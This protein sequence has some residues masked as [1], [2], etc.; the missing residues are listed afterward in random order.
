MKAL[1]K[2]PF[3]GSVVELVKRQ[4]PSCGGKLDETVILCPK[5]RQEN[6]REFGYCQF[7]GT[8]LRIVNGN[9]KFKG[10][11]DPEEG[12]RPSNYKEKAAEN[13]QQQQKNEDKVRRQ[14]RAFVGLS[15]AMVVFISSLGTGVS[16]RNSRTE[17]AADPEE[18]AAAEEETAPAETGQSG[19]F[20]DAEIYEVEGTATTADQ[21]YSLLEM[22]SSDVDEDFIEEWYFDYVLEGSCDWYILLFT[23]EEET[24]VYAV[25][26]LVYTDCVV[27]ENTDGAYTLHWSTDDTMYVPDYDGDA[28][29]KVEEESVVEDTEYNY[30]V[31]SCSMSY[32]LRDA[33]DALNEAPCSLSSLKD[34][35]EEAGYT[36]EESAYAADNCGASW[37]EQAKVVSQ[38]LLEE[39]TYS[40][41][42][43]VAELEE[44]GFTS[45]EAVYAAVNCGADWEEEALQAAENL[46]YYTDLSYDELVDEL[47]NE[48][49]FT[50]E[51][52]AYAADNCG[53]DWEE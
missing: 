44:Q 51:E 31:V 43:L 29:V 45:T 50:E 10:E 37:N 18:T 33:L 46:V 4:C 14:M 19:L 16:R 48:R 9:Y 30:V 22:E 27:R 11:P 41:D 35:L 42:F 21:T 20:A 34:Q 1:T 32:A 36:D 24:G 38:D 3:C 53:E 39:E 52:A 47:V 5:C 15:I 25:E 40:Y 28:L 2:C 49:G 13:I 6:F 12:S 17:D 23:D 26:G 7:C 8:D